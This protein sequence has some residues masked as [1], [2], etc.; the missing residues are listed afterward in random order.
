MSALNAGACP[1]EC[2]P[3]AWSQP[4]S[5]L[6][7]PG[8]PPAS[9]APVRPTALPPPP[10][11]MADCHHRRSAFSRTK[12]SP[13]PGLKPI[14]APPDRT[15]RLSLPVEKFEMFEPLRTCAVIPLT[16]GTF[17]RPNLLVVEGG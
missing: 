12:R 15:L 1:V 2:P 17:V 5:P 7:A 10:A 14:A 6:L 4:R 8:P 11:A 3:R 13:V 9:T 16:S